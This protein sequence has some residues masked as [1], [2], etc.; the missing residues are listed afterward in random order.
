[1]KLDADRIAV[2]DAITLQTV[3]PMW[4]SPAM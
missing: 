4:W 3:L 2:D 1:L